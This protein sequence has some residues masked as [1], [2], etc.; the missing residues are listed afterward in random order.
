[1]EKPP[2]EERELWYYHSC[3][4]PFSI[5]QTEIK[6]EQESKLLKTSYLPV[7]KW[8]NE[9]QKAD[10][11]LVNEMLISPQF[12]EITFCHLSVYAKIVPTE[13]S[14]SKWK[15]LILWRSVIRGVPSSPKMFQIPLNI[16]SSLGLLWFLVHEN[17]SQNWS[18]WESILFLTA[19]PKSIE[20]QQ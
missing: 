7:T 17:S 1:M 15:Q 16:F 4:W 8:A 20:G 13:S 9:Q 12:R 5:S 11:P 2:L 3:H 10:G 18:F 6:P 14:N 19:I